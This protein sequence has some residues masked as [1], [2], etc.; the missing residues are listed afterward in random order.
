[1]QGRGYLE[2][3]APPPL[4]DS[5]FAAR[6]VFAVDPN[7]REPAVSEALRAASF[8]CLVV[9]MDF[10]QHPDVC[11]VAYLVQTSRES[12]T[13]FPMPGG[14]P[15]SLEASAEALIALGARRVIVTDGERGGITAERQGNGEP[16]LRHFPAVPVGTVLDTTGAGDAFRAGLCW[17]LLL[18]TPGPW[19]LVNLVRVAS[20]AAAL[21]VQVL[22]SGSRTSLEDVLRL[23]QTAG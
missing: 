8:G 22:G 5:D 2:A 23:A 14:N 1:M 15:A 11:Q 19:P 6:P 4:P 3:V 7:L 10:Q 17:G 20:A 18:Q 12:L 21:H 16:L 9:A 13:R